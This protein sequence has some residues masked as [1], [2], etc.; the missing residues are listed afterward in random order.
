MVCQNLHMTYFQEVG[1]TQILADHVSQTIGMAFGWESR[2]LAITWSW[3]LTRVWSGPK[4]VFHV[5]LEFDWCDFSLNGCQCKMCFQKSKDNSKVVVTATNYDNNSFWV[6]LSLY[7]LPN[8]HYENQRAPNNYCLIWRWT[9]WTS[10]NKP[11]GTCFLPKGKALGFHVVGWMSPAHPNNTHCDWVTIGGRVHLESSVRKVTHLRAT[12]CTR[13]K[14]RDH[15]NRRTLI[16]WK[17][18]ACP[19]SLHTIRW[20]PKTQ[21]KFCGWEVYMESYMVDYGRG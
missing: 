19:S 13:P 18:K 15:C 9:P 11:P 17:G 12:S 3:S 14:T 1:M 20:M 6:G 10:T 8:G 2:A 5:N 16:G 21:R 7:G 4:V